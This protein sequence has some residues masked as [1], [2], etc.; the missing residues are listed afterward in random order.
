VLAAGER[1]VEAV[2]IEQGGGQAV[3]DQA[4]VA[5]IGTGYIDAE[6]GSQFPGED[7]RPTEDV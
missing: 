5:A 7:Q 6:G 3:D 2:D 1:R 4:Q